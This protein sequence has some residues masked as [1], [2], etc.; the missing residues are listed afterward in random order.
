VILYTFSVCLSLFP[1][2]SSTYILFHFC[3]PF[4]FIFTPCLSPFRFSFSLCVFFVFSVRNSSPFTSILYPFP[5]CLSLFPL[6]SSTYILFNSCLSFAF[7]FTPCLSPFPFLFSFCVLPA[8]LYG[9]VAQSHLYSN[10]ERKE[11][12]KWGR[13]GVKVKGK[14]SKG[15]KG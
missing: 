13:Q 15:K 1:L 12:R 2:P 5:V 14:E 9:I 8:F 4:P 3:F 7:T 11:K 6:S 10:T